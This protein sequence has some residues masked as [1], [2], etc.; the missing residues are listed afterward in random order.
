VEQTDTIEIVT[1]ERETDRRA[2]RIITTAPSTDSF[3]GWGPRM[4]SSL[5]DILRG[6]N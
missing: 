6:M 1:A 5:R 2:S 3:A 4:A